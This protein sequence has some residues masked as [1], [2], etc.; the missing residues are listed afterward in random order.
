MWTKSF[1]V[2]LSACIFLQDNYATAA[3]H[4]YTG[5]FLR[6]MGDFKHEAGDATDTL[7][8]V[9]H[10]H[11]N[12]D[13]PRH[14]L[15][16]DFFRALGD[17]KYRT[18]EKADVVVEKAKNQVGEIIGII[19]RQFQPSEGSPAAQPTPK[20]APIPDRPAP[21]FPSPSKPP[22]ESSPNP[23]KPASG[24]VLPPK[25]WETTPK[26]SVPEMTP[27]VRS[28][29]P[30]FLFTSDGITRELSTNELIEIAHYFERSKNV[31][32]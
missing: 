29:S 4:S 13:K 24:F 22:T 9:F 25:P 31:S 23:V 21:V 15:A 2:V 26:P 18:A 5:N 1:I 17:A 11:D 19:I 10:L 28:S 16:G 14:S 7:F 27:T 12:S 20:A 30:K 8:S 32:N 3:E 6:K